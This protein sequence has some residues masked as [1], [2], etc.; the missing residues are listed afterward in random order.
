MYSGGCQHQH[1][2]FHC[3]PNPRSKSIPFLLIHTSH[4]IRILIS[5]TSTT[6]STLR[7]TENPS[8]EWRRVGDWKASKHQST[9]TKHVLLWASSLSLPSHIIDVEHTGSV[10]WPPH[11]GTWLSL[12]APPLCSHDFY[13]PLVTFW[14]PMPSVYIITMWGSR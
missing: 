10:R 13:E 9:A 4:S 11:G 7:D 3:I 14:H 12:T 5:I 1:H 2:F 6:Y 8:S